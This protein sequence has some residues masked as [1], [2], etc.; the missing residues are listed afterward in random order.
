MCI[1]RAMALWWLPFESLNHPKNF[2]LQGSTEMRRKWNFDDVSVLVSTYE[3]I[4]LLP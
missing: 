4:G 1:A 2:F 3:T